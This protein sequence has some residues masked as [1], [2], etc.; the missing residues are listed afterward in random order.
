MKGQGVHR[1]LQS[2]KDHSLCSQQPLPE[3]A[4][5]SNSGSL[6]WPSA[7]S[8]P[9]TPTLLALAIDGKHGGIGNQGGAHSRICQLPGHAVAVITEALPLPPPPAAGATGCRV[10]G[11]AS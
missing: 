1:Y 7:F 2:R 8:T 4:I 11:T 6:V 3:S 10:E 5:V 9:E